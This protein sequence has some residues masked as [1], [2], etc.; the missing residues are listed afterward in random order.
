MTLILG[1]AA[2]GKSRFAER[3][4]T[5][6]GHPR[7]YIATAQ[8]FDAE[9]REKI[10][11]HQRDRGTDWTTIEAPIAL[12]DTL[13]ALPENQITLVDCLTLWLTNLI[14]AENGPEDPAALFLAAASACNFPIVTVSNEVG[15]S[16]IP[17]SSL[18]RR[19]QR[20]QGRLNARIAQQADLVVMVTAGLPHVLKGQLPE[21]L[22]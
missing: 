21:G 6:H 17:E 22:T 5:H 8:P 9:M 4:V 19:F 14:L 12:P 2:S 1:G 20:E 13:R 10:E 16:I 18:G 7:S 3:L 11:Q 15:H